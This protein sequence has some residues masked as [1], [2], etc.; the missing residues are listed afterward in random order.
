MSTEQKI[1]SAAAELLESGGT[2]ALTSRAVCNAAGI[3]APTL[4]HHFGDITG[5]VH[6]LVT[7]GIAEFMTGKRAARQSLDPATGLRKGWDTW[8]DFALRRPALFKLIVDR[9]A[10]EPELGREVH[11]IMRGNLERMSEQGDL[12]VN[13]DVAARAMQAAS[14]GV[15]S[16][17]TQGA[18]PV[19]VK[20]TGALLF[21]SVLNRLRKTSADAAT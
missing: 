4:Y 5:L 17:L 13:V 11:M 1:L 16:L 9:A 6:A 19:E 14:N 7:K 12:L 15:L 21:E 20:E 18:T 2:N 8:I 3:T 10:R